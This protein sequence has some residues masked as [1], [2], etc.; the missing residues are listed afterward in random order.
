M[1]EN[2]TEPP[3][4]SSM[5]EVERL[6]AQLMV[7]E[8]SDDCVANALKLGE[9][10]KKLG[11]KQHLQKSIDKLINA[12]RDKKSGYAR[13]SGALG[14]EGLIKAVGKEGEA[15]FVQNLPFLLEMQSDRGAPVRDA[16]ERATQGKTHP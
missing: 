6:M 10:V 8:T 2:S 1:T 4:E 7:S 3:Q 14:M 11:V 13:E 5:D 12:M 16:A 15:H 9:A